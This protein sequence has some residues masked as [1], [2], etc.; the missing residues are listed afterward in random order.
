[1]GVGGKGSFICYIE[2]LKPFFVLPQNISCNL[3]KQ[4]KSVKHK[5]QDSD[6][7]HNKRE[8][9]TATVGHEEDSGFQEFRNSGFR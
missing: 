9:E 5:L 6:L 8:P 7:E 3:A 4:K 2:S 1:L